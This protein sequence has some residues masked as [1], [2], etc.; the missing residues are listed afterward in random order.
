MENN[1]SKS[2]NLGLTILGISLAVAIVISV[3][4][5]SETMK[6]IKLSHQT[7]R[8][9]GYAEKTIKSDYAT[10]QGSYAVVGPN[11]ISNYTLLEEYK[12]IVKNFLI[13]N[14][15]PEKDIEFNAVYTTTQYRKNEKGYST[16]EVSGYLISQTV[17]VESN[18]VDLINRLSKQS[19]ELMKQGIIFKSYSPKYFYTK[20]NDLKIEM[21]GK[22]TK[23]ANERAK[24]LAKNSD[25]DVG[26]LR[27]A[28]QGVFQITPKNS[29]DVSDYGQFDTTEIEKVIKAVVTIEYSIHN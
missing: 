21:L 29:T 26:Q 13:K 22:A 6:A 24:V 4:F 28:S 11:I 1:K 16:G 7:I 19:S 14:G 27:Y 3:F 8:I 20:L 15:I 2:N 10:W 12:N 23:D 9:K 5:L 17:S 25:S 18:N